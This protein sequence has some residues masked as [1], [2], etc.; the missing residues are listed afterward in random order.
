VAPLVDHATTGTIRQRKCSRR[1]RRELDEQ[2]AD[3]GPDAER[4]APS[5]P[6][7][8]PISSSNSPIIGIKHISPKRDA[9]SMANSN[10]MG[11]GSEAND[12]LPMIVPFEARTSE[13]R[14]A[15]SAGDSRSVEPATAEEEPVCMRSDCATKGGLGSRERSRIASLRQLC[16]MPVASNRARRSKGELGYDAQLEL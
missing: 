6:P 2:T 8:T 7:G 3:Q 14:E 12:A 11:A 10:P 9:R 1:L 4:T 13:L 5:F 15:G 16:V